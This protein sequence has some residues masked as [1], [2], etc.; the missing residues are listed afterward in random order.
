MNDS[1]FFLLSKRFWS[2]PAS[3][4]V[5][6]LFTNVPQVAEALTEMGVTQEQAAAGLTVLLVWLVGMAMGKRGVKL[7]PKKEA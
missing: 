5:A 4:V 3:A 1:V 7:N 6:W 2:M